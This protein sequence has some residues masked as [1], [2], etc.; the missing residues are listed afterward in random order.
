MRQALGQCSLSRRIVGKERMV[1][2]LRQSLL[3][4]RGEETELLTYQDITEDLQVGG[5]DCRRGGFLLVPEA[6]HR[7]AMMN[8]SC[9]SNLHAPHLYTSGTCKLFMTYQYA[10]TSHMLSFTDNV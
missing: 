10:E 1:V 7:P 6:K 8:K 4:D 2:H 9:S 3:C 5:T